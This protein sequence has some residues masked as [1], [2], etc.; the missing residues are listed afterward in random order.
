MA[1][2]TNPT[3]TGTG[4]GTGGPK[5]APDIT[6]A[7][8]DTA[9]YAANFNDAKPPLGHRRALVEASR[10]HFCYDAPAILTCGG[11]V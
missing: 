8:L 4:T 3:G 5:G 10:C 9:D 11:Y 6:S 7:R 2:Q 1:Q